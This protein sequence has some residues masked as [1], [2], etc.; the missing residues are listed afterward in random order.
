MPSY[1]RIY[2]LELLREYKDTKTVSLWQKK[3]F[4]KLMSIVSEYL[5]I[6]LEVLKLK[7]LIISAKDIPKDRILFDD[8]LLSKIQGAVDIKTLYFIEQVYSKTLRPELYE[9]WKETF[10]IK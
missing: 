1:M 6:D 5:N 9:Q 7:K 4:L 8:L 10:K 2:L 3:H